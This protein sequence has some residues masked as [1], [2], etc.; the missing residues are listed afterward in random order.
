MSNYQNRL[1]QAIWNGSDDAFED[2][3]LAIYRQNLVM[4]AE[5]ALA[6]TYPTV[7]Q[8][9][10]EEFFSLLVRDFLN[11]EKLTE[12]DWGMWGKTLPGWL[13]NYQ[14]LENFPFISGCAK[15][16]W[17]CHLAERDR[18]ERPKSSSEISI[19]TDLT[20][21]SIDYCAGTHLLR[22][23]Y[24]IVDIKLA[25]LAKQDS[26]RDDLLRQARIKI[27][28]GIGQTALVWRPHWQA[29][30]REVSQDESDWLTITFKGESIS[31]ALD[32]VSTNFNFNKWLHQSTSDGL[33]TGFY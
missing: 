19:D 4:N 11:Y 6:I 28:Q 26:D 25:H 22:S 32:K 17:L 15:L 9:V 2:K 24:P 14:S 1:Y 5:R 21:L 13:V 33:V 18:K 16:D 20:R 7:V 3:G 8:L 23:D 30:V 12:G 10:G 27:S 31:K 29:L